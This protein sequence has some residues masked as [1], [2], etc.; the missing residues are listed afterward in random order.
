M[1]KIQWACSEYLLKA[2][3]AVYI[4]RTSSEVMQIPSLCRKG[5]TNTIVLAN[6]RRLNCPVSREALRRD[7]DGMQTAEKKK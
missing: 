4:L 3:P 7:A 2:L 5:K 6:R 1:A